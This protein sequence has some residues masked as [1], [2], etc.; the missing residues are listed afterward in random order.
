MVRAFGVSGSTGEAGDVLLV[1]LGRHP[2]T[3][4]HAAFR[5]QRA[6]IVLSPGNSS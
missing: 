2:G 3:N 1:R 6:G 4:R 5:G